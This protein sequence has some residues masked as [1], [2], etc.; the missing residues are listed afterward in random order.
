[1][2][3]AFRRRLD[4]TRR[5]DALR[6]IPPRRRDAPRDHPPAGGTIDGGT[7]SLQRIQNAFDV[8]CGEEVALHRVA[9]V[10][11]AFASHGRRVVWADET[12]GS[13]FQCDS[14]EFCHVCWTVVVEC[15]AEACLAARHV[16]EMEEEN[17]FAEFWNQFEDVFAHRTESRLAERDTVRRA[18]A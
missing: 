9:E 13:V 11:V 18:V 15:F 1:M 3:A 8:A 7:P 16:A 10:F 4:F 6:D 14:Q 2:A 12:I 5:R 17:P